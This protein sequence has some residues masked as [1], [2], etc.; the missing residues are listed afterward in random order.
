VR[1]RAAV[2]LPPAVIVVGASARAFAWSAWR[3]GIAVH[4]ADLFADADLRDCAVTVVPAGGGQYPAGLV[5][6][7]A[8]LPR[9]PVCYTGALENHPRIVDRLAA[10]RP[11]A[12]NP[13]RRL[14][15]VR[16][17]V[18]LAR[19]VRAAGLGFPVTRAT[20]AGLPT[21]GSFL[22]KPRASAG[23][24]GIA[25]WRGE[26]DRPR[27]GRAVWQR[28]VAGE[29][30]G[31]AFVVAAGR[32]RLFGV[33]RQLVGAAWCGAR[34]FAWCGAVD[35][36]PDTIPAAVRGQVERLGAVLAEEFGLVGL[37]GA[38]L[39]VDDAGDVHVIEVNPRPTASMELVERAGGESVA[40]AHLAACGLAPPTPPPDATARQAK[41]VVFGDRDLVVDE[42]LFAALLGTRG[43]WTEDDGGWPALADL[44]MP[45]SLLRA[46]GPL[47]TAF[48]AAPTGRAAVALLRRRVAVVR[49]LFRAAP[50]VS[51]PADAA[52]ARP[53]LRP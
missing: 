9:V 14:R 52:A 19:A 33:S 5:A 36:A 21:D 13:G 30:W 7:V 26:A 22:V 17:P 37:V 20:P 48:A 44:P 42:R 4:A 32:S 25:P 28:L 39:V 43:R 15:R 38:D 27:H 40:R 53:P 35:V 46:G 11:L 16:D 41:A 51:P 34:P 31:A 50:R 8:G 1:E 45:G 3:A 23:G 47:V 12:G 29:A 2:N 10:D 24:R 18:Q 6:A 49:D